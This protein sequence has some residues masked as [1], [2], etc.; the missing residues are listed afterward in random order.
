MSVYSAPLYVKWKLCN[1]F[2]I[3]D[4]DKNNP[5]V[6]FF[7][8]YHALDYFSEDLRRNDLDVTRAV[9]F[10]DFILFVVLSLFTG[11][12]PNT[13]RKYSACV[14]RTAREMRED[15]K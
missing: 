8:G 12:S 14:G 6:Q 5:L 4:L 13:G 2:N 9:P 3:I 15:N 10:H 7:V 11:Y 1:K